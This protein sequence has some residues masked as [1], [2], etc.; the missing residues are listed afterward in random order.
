MNSWSSTFLTRCALGAAVAAAFSAA[1]QQTI[2]FSKPTENPEDKANSFLQD[3]GSKLRGRAGD[4]D[5]PKQ[6]F[7]LS[8]DQKPG[9]MAAPPVLSPS[10]KDAL[11]KRKNWTLMTPQEIMGVPTAE[12]IMGLPDPTGDDKRTPEERFLRRQNLAATT[13]A[14][15]AL[16]RPEAVLDD[17]NPFTLRAAAAADDPFAKPDPRVVSGSRKY[18]DQLV[19]APADSPF[20]ANQN[21]ESTSAFGQLAPLPKPDLAQIAAME[22]FRALME[23]SAP[24]EKMTPDKGFSA[25]PSLSVPD[26]NLQPVPL[27][28]PLGQTYSPLQS[29]LGRPTGI[30]PLPGLTG[31]APIAPAR[32]PLVQLP[33]WLSK[34]PPSLD[35]P[36]GQVN[37]RTW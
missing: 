31:P 23:P 26:R 27:F 7:D 34:D 8:P 10:L 16:R 11:D 30:M 37:T 25:T 35:G 12:Q 14:T 19:N 4:F 15:N 33:P 22:R 28:N 1:A 24:P 13:S 6:L 18:F 3:S 29:P 32:K 20:G 9:P 5:A 21:Q 2:L 36:F 17:A